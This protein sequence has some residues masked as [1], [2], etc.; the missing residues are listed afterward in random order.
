M[1]RGAARG[2]STR[3]LFIYFASVLCT[4]NLGLGLCVCIGHPS[5]EYHIWQ[6]VVTSQLKRGAAWVIFWMGSVLSV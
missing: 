1:D 2:I 6:V 4:V 3:V 5:P